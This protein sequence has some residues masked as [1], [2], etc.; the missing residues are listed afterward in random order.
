[1]SRVFSKKSRSI[2][3]CILLGVVILGGMGTAAVTYYVTPKYTRVGYTP[4][5]PVPFSH[6]L[7][8]GQLGLDCRY[9]HTHV[10]QSPSANIPTGEACMN[11][12]DPAKANIKGTSA[13]L[14]PLREAWQQGRPV[15]WVRVHKVPDFVYFNH[16]VHVQRGVGCV[17][18]HGKINEMPVVRHEQP[19]S[20]A[21]CLECHRNP[22]P[23]LRPAEKVTDLNWDP[24][25]DWDAKAAGGI[26]SQSAFAQ[27]M[28]ELH[29]VQPP[30]N[31]TGCHR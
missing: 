3:G 8:A 10:G 13:A 7:H 20:M 27:K 4:S 29:G 2:A 12:H 26:E 25:K 1:M 16:A 23:N 28:I 18:C 22:S 19:L 5:Q 14:A 6:E 11:C 17:S 31:C 15:E 9:C 21:W 24:I 30:T